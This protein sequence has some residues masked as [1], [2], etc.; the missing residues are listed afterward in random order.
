MTIQQA[1]ESKKLPKNISK[2]QWRNICKGIGITFQQNQN[3]LDLEINEEQLKRLQYSR[4]V[5]VANVSNIMTASHNSVIANYD[6]LIM[7]YKALSNEMSSKPYLADEKKRIDELI[8]NLTQA[9]GKYQGFMSGFEISE[10]KV[11][12]VKD[13]REEGSSS[14]FMEEDKSLSTQI[15]QNRSE[16]LDEKIGVLDERLQAEYK[17]L[18]SLQGVTYKSKFKQNKHNRRIQ[19][20]ISKIQSL[21]GKQGILQDK[22]TQII[23]IQTKKYLDKMAKKHETAAKELARSQAHQAKIDNI[24]QTK[25]SYKSDIVENLKELQRLE[26]EKGLGAKIQRATLRME[27]RVMNATINR[28]NRKEGFVNLQNQVCVQVNRGIKK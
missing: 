10:Q 18:R 27:N 20:K 11:D 26:N 2:S 21:R 14:Y 17:E 5:H 4:D 1:I 28:L 15:N 24:E 9:K 16:K 7:D 6:K 8:G 3:I 25:Q 19:R 12:S 23:E 22:Q 13:L